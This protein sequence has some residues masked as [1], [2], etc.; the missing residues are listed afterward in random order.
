MSCQHATIPEDVFKT[1][2]RIGNT[3][4]VPSHGGGYGHPAFVYVSKIIFCAGIDIQN[5]SKRVKLLASCLIFT[6][7]VDYQVV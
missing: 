2:R 5:S 4:L 1:K 7:K 3:H 6:A